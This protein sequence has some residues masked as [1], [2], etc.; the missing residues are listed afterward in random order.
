ME[1][2]G[3]FRYGWSATATIIFHRIKRSVHLG[4]KQTAA[5]GADG[6][7]ITSSLFQNL[8]VAHNHD[9]DADRAFPVFEWL[10]QHPRPAD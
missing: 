9:E 10:N 6:L 5:V 3:M 7:K 4:K 1:M 8:E 2:A